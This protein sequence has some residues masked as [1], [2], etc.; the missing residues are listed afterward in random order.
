MTAHNKAYKF[1]I[2][3]TKEQALLI[4]RTFGC[5]RFVY[6]KMLAERIET[7]ETLKKDK[8]A[9][10]KREKPATRHPPNIKRILSG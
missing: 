2:Y 4:H 7:Y 9:V 3:P 10:K 8:E 6:N 1:R 5:V